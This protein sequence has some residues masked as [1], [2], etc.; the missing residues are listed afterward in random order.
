VALTPPAKPT[1]EPLKFSQWLGLIATAAAALLLWQLRAVL[2]ELFA[3]VVLA[4]ALCTLVG[5]VRQRLR[6]SRPLALILSLVGLVLLFT[7]LVAAVV[8]PFL[9]QF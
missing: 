6:C 5:M 2:I 8:P 4:M 1:A 9:H 3:A 7:V